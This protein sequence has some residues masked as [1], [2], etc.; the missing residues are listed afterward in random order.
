VE[1]QTIERFKQILNGIPDFCQRWNIDEFALVDAVVCSDEENQ[2]PLSPVLEENIL[3]NSVAK[4]SSNCEVSSRLDA[5]ICFSVGVQPSLL[6]LIQMQEEFQ[7]Q[8]GQTIHFWTKEALAQSENYLRRQQ[9]LNSA[10]II[11]PSNRA[12]TVISRSKPLTI[13]ERDECLL[14][15]I[16]IACRR[17]QKYT[18][19]LCWEQF[20]H[21]DCTLLQDAAVRQLELI[22]NAAKCISPETRNRCSDVPWVKLIQI[23]EGLVCENHPVEAEVIWNAIQQGIPK[24]VRA[25][26]P[27]VRPEA[28]ID[29]SHASKL[30]S[31][32]DSVPVF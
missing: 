22:G 17:I 10:Q 21:C 15:D 25:I 12:S 19:D 31:D 6:D 24:L 9:I 32:Y 30:T 23:C 8:F 13:A 28:E 1:I 7:Q 29:S 18:S 2:N 20:Q 11:Y 26:E 5:L 16:L 27:L 3:M 14:L 4:L